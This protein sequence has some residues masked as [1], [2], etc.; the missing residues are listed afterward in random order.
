V[1][2]GPAGFLAVFGGEK[3]LVEGWSGQRR[4]GGGVGVV[5]VK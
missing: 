4:G 1:C 3:G 5:G 2:W